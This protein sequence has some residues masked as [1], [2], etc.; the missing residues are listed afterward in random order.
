MEKNRKYLKKN[1]FQALFFSRGV[2]NFDLPNRVGLLNQHGRIGHR[3]VV[4]TCDFQAICGARAA[5]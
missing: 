2:E 3:A 1:N 4:L 5:L